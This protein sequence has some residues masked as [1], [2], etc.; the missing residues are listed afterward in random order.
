V[1][2]H[3][4]VTRYFCWS[5]LENWV[6][7]KERRICWKNPDR[8]GPDALEPACKKGAP[9]VGWGGVGWGD[10]SRRTDGRTAGFPASCCGASSVVSSIASVLKLH[11]EVFQCTSHRRDVHAG[12][13]WLAVSWWPYVITHFK[14]T[15][16]GVVSSFEVVLMIQKTV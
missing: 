5:Q 14:G 3:S 7:D 16:A 9:G 15:D 6:G 10:R 13:F 11:Q 12:M 1:I 8:V 2:G 4:E